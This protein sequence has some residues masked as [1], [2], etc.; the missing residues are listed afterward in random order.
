[1]IVPPPLLSVVGAEL[2]APLVTITEPVGV[3]L[4]LPPF[5]T[6]AT[7]NACVVVTLETDGVTVIVGV[8]AVTSTDVV[9]ESLA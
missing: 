1:L 5:T 9:P 4:P 7:E 8:A 2:K 3:G 6:M